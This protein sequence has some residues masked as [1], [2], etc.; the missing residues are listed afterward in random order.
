MSTT[1]NLPNLAVLGFVP[2]AARGIFLPDPASVRVKNSYN[3]V[4]RKER[5]YLLSSRVKFSFYPRI[6]LC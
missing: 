2:D 1:K 3:P 4:L 5:G 6:F